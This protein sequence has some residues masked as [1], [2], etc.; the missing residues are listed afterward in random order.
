M[1]RRAL[2]GDRRDPGRLRRVAP[3]AVQADA[4]ERD[5]MASARLW[6]AVVLQAIGDARH[7][8]HRETVRRWIG[9]ADFGRLCDLADT[10]PARVRRAI[11]AELLLPV[12]ERNEYRTRKLGHVRKRRV[13]AS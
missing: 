5:A 8:E 3:A 6:A 1:L 7:K 12:R 2:I 11:E 4:A 13:S 10:D 9:T